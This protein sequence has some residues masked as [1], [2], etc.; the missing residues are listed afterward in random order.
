[1]AADPAPAFRVAIPDDAYWRR[2]VKCQDACPVH[3]DARGYVTAIADGDPE[4][5]YITARDP[6]PFASICGR[7]C[8]APCEVACRRGDIDAP[9]A[10][11]ALKR[12]VTERYGVE[13]PLRAGR[14]RPAVEATGLGLVEAAKAVREIRNAEDATGLRRLG[15][16]PHP[17]KGKRVAVVGSG[18]SG[19]TCAHDLALLGYRV[20]V[21]EKQAVPGGMLVL[22]VPEYRLPRDLVRAEIQAVLAWAWSF[23]PTRPSAGTSRWRT[24]GPR[25]TRRSSWPSG[26]TRGA[27]SPSRGRSW[28]AYS[29]RWSSSSTSTWASRWTWASG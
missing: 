6:N 12:F 7:V 9:I 24:C 3:T 22:G 28:T 16:M 26:A 1:M 29:A 25:A 18:V 17:G 14:D 15:R 21:F 19:L 10:I 8:A 11:R 4:R 23:A 2:Q 27:G 5:A 20:T 13:A